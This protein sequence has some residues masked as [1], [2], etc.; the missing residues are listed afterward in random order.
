MK[1][2]LAKRCNAFV[3]RSDQIFIS[4]IPVRVGVIRK[5]QTHRKLQRHTMLRMRK[6]VFVSLAWQ[7]KCVWVG[8]GLNRRH[9]CTEPVHFT[10]FRNKWMYCCCWCCCCF[11]FLLPLLML[12]Y[13]ITLYCSRVSLVPTNFRRR[14]RYT[15]TQTHTYM[16]SN[17]CGSYDIRNAKNERAIILNSALAYSRVFLFRQ[18]RMKNERETNT[19][20]QCAV[21]GRT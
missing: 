13:F 18:R 3:C 16:H 12:Y 7:S 6:F 8:R 15:G 1:C 10:L 21:S 17:W 20:S 4:V 5:Q 19:H 9:C 14:Q 2:E 11:L